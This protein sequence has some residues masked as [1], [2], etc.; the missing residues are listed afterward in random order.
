VDGDAVTLSASIGS[1]TTTASGWAWSFATT[2][3]PAQSQTV[4]ITGT[5]ALGAATNATFSLVVQN[6]TPSV[7]AGSN[8][9]VASNQSFAFSGSFSDAGVIDNPWS[10][11]ITWG[12]GS[13]N[14]GSTASQA[15]AI[16][17]NHQFCGAANYTVTLYVTD[18]DGAEGSASRTVTVTYVPVT[19]DILQKSVNLGS[20]GMLPVAVL[21]TATFDAT[22]L[23]PATIVLGDETG[24][25]TP[26]AKRNN[27]RYFASAEDVN[28]DGRLDLV[29]QFSV[30]ALVAN[31]DLT[32]ST[33][34]LVLRGFLADGCTNV[35]GSNTVVIVP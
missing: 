9:T 1:L 15:A 10:W 14:T 18:K 17:A 34:S 26:V 21:S 5:D 28:G 19:V 27:S 23:D 30:P 7:N 8:S 16:T 20:K 12:D 33:T 13:Q 3:G 32:S 35:R 25:D 22:T 24:S 6:V 4:T 29:L 31:G 11:K 2:D